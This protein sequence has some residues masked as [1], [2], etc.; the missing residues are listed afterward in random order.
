MGVGGGVGGGVREGQVLQGFT[1]C[2]SHILT[3]PQFRNFTNHTL[4]L[5][6]PCR[7]LLFHES[8]V[9]RQQSV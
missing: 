4:R 1:H 7:L 8:I 2:S 3:F 9:A 5:I 6:A